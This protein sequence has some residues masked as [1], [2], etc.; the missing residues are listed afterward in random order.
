MC[1]RMIRL[2]AVAINIG[3]PAERAAIGHADSP[4][5]AGFWHF[6]LEQ[7]RGPHN[8]AHIREQAFLRSAIK[9]L[10]IEQK[11]G[12]EFDFVHHVPLGLA[13]AVACASPGLSGQTWRG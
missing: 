8:L 5:L 10:R 7:W 1:I 6:R 11:A 4:L 3:H 2:I 13:R 12:R 9:R